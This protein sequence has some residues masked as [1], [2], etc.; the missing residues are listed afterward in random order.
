MKPVGANTYYCSIREFY[1][2]GYDA[3]YYSESWSLLPCFMLVSCL[4]YS[5]AVKTMVICSSKMLVNLCQ[6]T[7]CYVAEDRI[8]HYHQ[9][10]SLKSSGL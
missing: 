9:C 5:S 7:R 3:M 1:L 8:L 2:L 10:E 4:V 6:T